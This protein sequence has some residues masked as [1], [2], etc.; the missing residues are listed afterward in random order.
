MSILV[1]QLKITS[2]A[3]SYALSQPRGVGCD[4][5]GRADQR[6][7][8]Y[9]YLWLNHIVVLQKPTQSCKG[10]I[11]HLKNKDLNNCHSFENES[12]S[13]ESSS[14]RPNGRYS[15]WSSPGQN[16]GMQGLSLLPG[17]FPTQGLNPGLPHCRRILSQ[18]SYQGRP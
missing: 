13:V 10:I 11:L 12:R 1:F 9:I 17:I 3:Q 2:E 14:L 15:P 7:G 6:E 5:S 16:T 18:L 4:W 8:I